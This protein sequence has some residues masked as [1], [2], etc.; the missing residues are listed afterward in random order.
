MTDCA[1]EPATAAKDS[2]MARNA[3]LWDPL[4]ERNRHNGE[5][6]E[7]KLIA[8]VNAE[9]CH[10]NVNAALSAIGFRRNR[11]RHRNQANA[12]ISNPRPFR[13]R[14]K[15]VNHSNQLKINPD[16]KAAYID[17]WGIRGSLVNR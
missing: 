4:P 10:Y 3:R 7:S 16:M 14:K 17:R 1:T 8:R 11:S 13:E 2:V 15:A 12:T 5:R 9:L 6:F